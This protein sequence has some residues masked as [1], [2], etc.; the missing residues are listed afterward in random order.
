M[1]VDERNAHFIT[2]DLDRDDLWPKIKDYEGR[3]FQFRWEFGLDELPVKPGLITIRGPRQSGKSTWLEMQILNTLEEFGRGSA[4]F[5]NGDYIYSHEE[6]ESKI[7]ELEKSYS[8]KSKVKRLFIDEITQIKDWQRILKRLI[9][10]GHLKELLIVTT[11]SNA[12]DLRHGSERLPGR[13]GQ[14]QRTEYIFL[15]ISFKEYWY[16]VKDEIGM[17]NSDLLW[18]Y[19]LS[20]GSPL[21]IA[22]IYRDEKIDDTFVSLIT[23]WILGDIAQSGRNR[24]FALNL[25]RKMYEFSPNPVSY[26]K[27]AQAAGLANNT[28]ALDYIE[29]FSDLLFVKPML[30]WDFNKNTTLMRKPS[31]FQ[32]INLGAAWVFH[33]K[34]PRYL[35]EIRQL[36]NRERGSMYEWVVAQ[37]LWRREQLRI[38]KSQSKSIDALFEA[39]L[40]YWASEKNEIDFVLPNGDLYEVKSG[41]L[42][43]REFSWFSK[44]FPKK[45]LKIIS[46]TEFET[47][48]LKSVTLKEFLVDTESALYFDSDRAP[49]LFDEELRGRIQFR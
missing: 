35:H 37:E 48:Q 26:T 45:Q 13:K 29:R 41:K 24:I 39:E 20:G 40:M 15:P 18:G 33:P 43:P 46:D 10:S 12:A 8:K 23:D 27:L 1:N 42:S 28:A 16:T 6:F 9:D 3:R 11:G 7:L 2:G 44:I 30:Q 32:F 38:Q 47:Q 5:L 19:I 21:A 31:K 4:F 25:L 22:E 34:A 49:W 14:L 36:E 17:F